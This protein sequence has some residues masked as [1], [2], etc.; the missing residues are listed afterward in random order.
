M[1]KQAVEAMKKYDK[2]KADGL[3]SAELERLRQEAE[4]AFQSVADYQF[5]ML[6]GP[7]LKRD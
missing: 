7:S 2:A 1:Y 6:G 4:Y 5:E 3:P